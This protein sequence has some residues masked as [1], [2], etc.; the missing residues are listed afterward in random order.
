MPDVSIFRWLVI[1]YPPCPFYVASQFLLPPFDTAMQPRLSRSQRRSALPFR[2]DNIL[3]R[4]A[5]IME[6]GRP[7]KTRF[8]GVK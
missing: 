5:S 2:S 7:T 4:P 3:L 1:P 6:R 8:Q